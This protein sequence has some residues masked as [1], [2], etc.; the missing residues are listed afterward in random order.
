MDI[1]HLRPDPGMPDQVLVEPQIRVSVRLRRERLA[2]RFSQQKLLDPFE[3]V[4]QASR[5]TEAVDRI[6]EGM[7]ACHIRL[8]F[9][10]AAV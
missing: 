2:V 5:D 6:D 8:E 4:F 1:E 10:G 7:Q 9:G 3:R